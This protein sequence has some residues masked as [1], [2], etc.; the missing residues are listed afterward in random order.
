MTPSNF[1]PSYLRPSFGWWFSQYDWGTKASVFHNWIVA[2]RRLAVN[3]RGCAKVT[4]DVERMAA[5]MELN[6]LCHTR[7]VCT[8]AS[9]YASSCVGTHG[10]LVVW[11]SLRSIL[12]FF[13]KAQQYR[14]PIAVRGRPCSNWGRNLSSF[15]VIKGVRY[16]MCRLHKPFFPSFPGAR[17]VYGTNRWLAWQGDRRISCDQTRRGNMRALRS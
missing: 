9:S 5:M 17:L 16:V 2:R 13:S 10:C 4:C 3:Q 12:I 7:V 11:N 8:I 14:N 1:V 15:S 6:R